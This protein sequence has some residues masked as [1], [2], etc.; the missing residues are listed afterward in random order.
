MDDSIGMSCAVIEASPDRS[1]EEIY[2]ALPRLLYI[3][4]VAVAA[5]VA[6]ST[7]L[8]RLLQTYPRQRLLIAEGNLWNS[9]PDKRLPHVK[10]ETFTVGTARLLNTRFNSI[11]SGLLHLTAD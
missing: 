11:Y 9:H 8:Y 5:T 10:Y 4:D 7:L 1:S 2:T 3:G 6:G